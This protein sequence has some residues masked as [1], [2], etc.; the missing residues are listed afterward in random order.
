MKIKILQRYL[1]AEFFKYL[2]VAILSLAAFYIVVD[3]ISNIGA[4]TKHSPDI[5]YVI[6]Y[7]LYKLPE[8]VYR[9]LPLS[10]LLSTLL[11]LAF[12]NKNNEIAAV[13]SSGLSMLRFFLPLILTGIIISLSAFLL[14]NFV[15]VNTNI[16]RRFVMQ[17]YINKNTSYNIGSV[18]R[19][20]TKDIMIHYKKYIITAQSLD[21]SKKMIKGVNIYVFDN[22]FVLQK[23]Y[24]AKEGYFEYKNLKLINGR[25]DEFEFNNKSGFS[26]KFFKNIEMPINLNLNFFKSYTLKPEFLSVASLSKMLAVAEKTESGVNYILTDFYSK[27]SYPIINLILI[28]VGIS[29][30]LLL[31]KKGG[32]PIAIGISIVFAFTWWIINSIA[33]SLGESSQLN[34]LLAAFMADIIFLLFAVYLMADID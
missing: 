8:I 2:T 14:S 30:G 18:Y 4:F 23:R 17:R 34:P 29:V 21:P 12:F 6:L 7:F 32:A 28:L 1:L 24:I 31:E 11:T 27:I 10:A 3:F 9:V 5:G 25:L 26:E 15:A 33:L 19:Y 20:R 16:S 22:N 13:K